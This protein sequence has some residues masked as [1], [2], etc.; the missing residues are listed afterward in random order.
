MDHRIAE[1]TPRRRLVFRRAGRSRGQT[2]VEFALVFPL[3]ITLM[4]GMIEFG[5]MFNAVLAVSYGARDAALQGAEAGPQTG[6]DCVILKAVEAAVG[7]P[8]SATKIQTVEIYQVNNV[9]TQIGSKT[10]YTRNGV[11]NAVPC[12]NIDG[13]TVPYAL[14]ANNYPETSRCNYLAGCPTAPAANPHPTVDNIA[15]RVTYIH[16]WV[17]P[18][19]NFIGGGTG[20]FSFDRV[21]V[22]RMEPVL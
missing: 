5:F 11:A 8:A 22:M 3:F 6:A 7:P 1:P 2:L 4:L 13:S 21:S 20:G 12:L 14:T 9:G 10:I 15:V 16:T 18:L 17:T 19:R